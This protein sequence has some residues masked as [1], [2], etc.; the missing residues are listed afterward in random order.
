MYTLYSQTA[1]TIC[2]LLQRGYS[3]AKSYLT[4]GNLG[5]R[6][7]SLMFSQLVRGWKWRAAS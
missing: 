3:E 4:L 2:P 1:F 7:L 6:R 5:A